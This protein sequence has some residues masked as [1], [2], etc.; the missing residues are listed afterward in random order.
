MPSQELDIENGNFTRIHNRILEELAKLRLSSRETAILFVILRK[1][2]GWQ[3]KEAH[4]PFKCFREMTGISY[5]HIS[6]A[7]K[8][9]EQRNL[10][11]KI[12]NKHNSTYRFNKHFSTWKELPKSATDKRKL[13]ESVTG[14]AGIGNK[15]LP[16]SVTGVAGIGNK[17]SLEATS[18]KGLPPP[19]ETILKK[20]KETSLKKDIPIENFIQ[21]LREKNLY[22]GI[23]ID[24]ELRKMDAWLLLPQNKQRRKTKRFIVNWLNKIDPPLL[25]EGRDNYGNDRRR[26]NQGSAGKTGDEAGGT[27]GD[28]ELLFRRF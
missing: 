22:P 25:V 12:G 20:Y 5:A 4:I 14:V 3:Q 2:Y 19:K 23:D 26:D 1:T 28:D 7:L 27:Q 6:N 17:K 16:E 18:T 10:V 15:V 24:R 9:L 11:A 13:P 21:Q 8:R